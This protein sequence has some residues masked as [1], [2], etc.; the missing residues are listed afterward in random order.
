MERLY[1]GAFV[2]RKKDI[3]VISADMI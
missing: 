1:N 3:M 2:A